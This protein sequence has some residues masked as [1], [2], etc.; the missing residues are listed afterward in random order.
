MCPSL[1]NCETRQTQNVEGKKEKTDTAPLPSHQCVYS[2]THIH[3]RLY[4]CI[5]RIQKIWHQCLSIFI[6]I[7]KAKVSQA[8]HLPCCIWK[9]KVNDSPLKKNVNEK[10]LRGCRC[11]YGSVGVFANKGDNHT[12]NFSLFYKLQEVCNDICC[13]RSSLKASQCKR[14]V[15]LGNKNGFLQVCRRERSI[16]FLPQY[17]KYNIFKEC[18]WEFS[19]ESN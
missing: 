8:E 19:V 14:R 7:L 3:T 12:I 10:S 15:H 5:K 6:L 2:L 16:I 1:S 17:N 13:M 11:F 18:V 4:H 9:K